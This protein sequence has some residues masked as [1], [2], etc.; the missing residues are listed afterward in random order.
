[1]TVRRG[2]FVVLEGGEGAGKSTQAA[3]L[4]E[5]L[6]A[7]LTRE[8]GDTELGARLR[9]LLLD[10]TGPVDDRAEA[11]LMM[12]D[13][14]QHVTELVEPALA[15]GR[16]VVCDRFSGSTVAYQGYG[17]GQDVGIV[18]AVSAWAANGLEPDLVLWLDVDREVA[19]ARVGSR[20]D[21]IESAG[22][23]FHRRVAEGFAQQ[24]EDEP[25]I[26]VRVD[27]GGS[28]DEVAERIEVAVDTHLGPVR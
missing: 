11:L 20:P 23:E 12:A 25:G 9:T 21:R 6:G 1:M 8:P 3:R 5:R 26:W 4:A 17:R 22:E 15:S 10:T 13:R 2:R 27:A 16:D 7:V 28:Q 18:A 19:A 24:C 14:A